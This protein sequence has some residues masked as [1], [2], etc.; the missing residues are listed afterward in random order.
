MKIKMM[1][2]APDAVHMAVNTAVEK[3]LSD[4][5]IHPMTMGYDELKDRR[6]REQY[7][8]L[9]KWFKYNEYI[10]IDFDTEAGT[11]EILDPRR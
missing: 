4:D 2:K 5:K 11:F 3:S 9:A 10:W 6:E 1:L 7:E 8:K